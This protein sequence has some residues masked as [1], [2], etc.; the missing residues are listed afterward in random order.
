[1]YS[2]NIW[3]NVHCPGHMRK[4]VKTPRV[5]RIGADVRDLGRLA[6]PRV[7]Y[8]SVL[9]LWED[10]FS[11]CYAGLAPLVRFQPDH[12]SPKLAHCCINV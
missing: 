4:V 3:D 9:R 1:M 2:L 11:A 6:P 12:F 7:L 5:P 10:H 8:E